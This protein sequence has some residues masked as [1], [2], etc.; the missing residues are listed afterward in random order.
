MISFGWEKRGR[1]YIPPF[2]WNY[3]MEFYTNFDFP[4]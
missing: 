2:L 4:R 3:I 1:A